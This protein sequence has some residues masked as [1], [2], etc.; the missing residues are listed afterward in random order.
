[1]ENGAI[2]QNGGHHTSSFICSSRTLPHP[3]Q[4]LES[5]SL[6]L[7]FF[8]W[9]PPVSVNRVWQEKLCESL[10]WV[11]QGDTASQALSGHAIM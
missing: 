8:G 2:F 4:E 5:V 6:P 11:T 9:P 7:N 10:G 1:M 3:H